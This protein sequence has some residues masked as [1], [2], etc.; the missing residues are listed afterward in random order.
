[1]VSWVAVALSVGAGSF[2]AFWGGIEGF[3]EGWYY[4]SLLRNVNLMV[5]QYL[6]PMLMVA[7]AGLV[8]ARWP[9]L[10]GGLHA[11]WALAAAWFFRGGGAVVVY[12]TVVLP[13]LLLGTLYWLGR[14]RRRGL[15]AAIVAGVPL[16]TL[17]ACAAGPAVTVA[18]RSD[19][20]DRGARRV[21]ATAWT[22][23]GRRP[24]QA[25]R[26]TA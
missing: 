23:C 18:T 9:R 12:G 13:L 15:A 2:W 25:G 14:L 7:V 3:H 6:S 4:P 21:P 22:S 1:V 5:A 16:V 17:M 20:G 19:D 26:R 8:G 24:A 10:G 11:T